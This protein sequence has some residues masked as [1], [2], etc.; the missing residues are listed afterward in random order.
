MTLSFPTAY[1]NIY[2]GY[3][4][5]GQIIITANKLSKN[6]GAAFTITLN[7]YAVNGINVSGTKKLTVADV[8]SGEAVAFNDSSVFQITTSTGTF[9]WN[10]QHNIQWLLGT[11]TKANIADDL[12]LTMGSASSDLFTSVITDALQSRNYCL[13]IGSG[14]VE[15]TPKDLSKRQVIYPD[16]CVNHANVIINNETIRI[17]F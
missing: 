5:S 2:D 3:V 11:S 4:R 12:F 15:I 1:C 13:W 17:N 6:I 14:Q 7:N 9:T 16:S 10:A 8:V